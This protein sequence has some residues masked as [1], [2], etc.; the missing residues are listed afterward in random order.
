MGTDSS[1]VLPEHLN[2][3]L[4]GWRL[5]SFFLYKFCLVYLKSLCV[6]VLPSPRRLTLEA[7]KMAKLWAHGK[8]YK[9]K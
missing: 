3:T 5:P 9:E 6:V 2:K 1:E 4:K 7:T 8:A